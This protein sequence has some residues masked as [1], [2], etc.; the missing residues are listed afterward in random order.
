MLLLIAV[1]AF[2]SAAFLLFRFSKR[3]NHE[4]PDTIPIS[5]EPPNARP[6]F[7]PSDAELRLEANKQEAIEIARRE[8]RANQASRAVVDAA[9]SNWRKVRDRKAAVELLRVTAV[10]GLDGDFSKAAT[11]IIEHF[12]ESGVA[13]ITTNDLALLLDSHYRLL[14]ANERASGELFWL[15]QEIGKLSSKV[16]NNG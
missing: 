6:L 1:L 12:R 4:L 2:L 7:E 15:K 13:G 11:E 14:S 10:S 16:D 9:L 3:R 8:Y 5:I